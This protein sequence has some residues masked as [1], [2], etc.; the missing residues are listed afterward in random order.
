MPNK[1][2]YLPDTIKYS[3][4]MTNTDDSQPETNLKSGGISN[5]KLA[6]QSGQVKQKEENGK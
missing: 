4:W 1:D 2:E 6:N 5:E 3:I